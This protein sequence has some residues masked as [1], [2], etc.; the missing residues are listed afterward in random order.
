MFRGMSSG[1]SSTAAPS[2]ASSVQTAYVA[3][4]AATAALGGFLF[5]FD[6]AVINGA[7]SGL[8]HTYGSTSAGTGFAV[9]S[10][11]IGCAIGALLAGRIADLHGRRIVMIV[12]AVIFALTAAGAGLASST[13]L[14]ILARFISGI[15]VGAASV[16]CP[17]YIAEI[18]P[19]GIRGRLASLQQ[20]GIVVGIFAALL[21]DALI[22]QAAGGVNA[23]FHGEEAWRWM[24]IVE[25]A[26]S[27]LFGVAALLIPESPRFLLA[28]RR[29]SA[30]LSVLQRIDPGTAD[31]TLAEIEKTV[32]AE[33]KPSLADLRGPGGTVLAIVWIGVALSALQ[34]LVGINSIFYYG[35][36][37]WESVG[38]TQADSLRIN[39][40]TS[41]VNIVSTFVAMAFVDKVGRRPLLLWGSVAMAVTLGVLV[42]TLRGGSGALSHNAGIVALLAANLYV[43]AF[44]VSWGPCVWILLG[45]MFPNSIRGSAMAL[46]VF[47]QWIANWLITVS[48][49]G[50]VSALG[51]SG[52]YAMYMFFAVL[53]FFFVQRFIRETRGRALEEM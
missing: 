23:D 16:V 14:F 39:V 49:P 17:A 46:A 2:S 10:I 5:G 24:F 7:I 18:S 26:P 29:K 52:A 6:S 51:P 4:L 38:F 1:P 20:M 12:S 43:F 22:A 53:A 42:F 30:A 11:L 40:L 37:L 3:F 33:R 45:E 48:F 47:A 9:A 28:V 27:I 31:E 50:I 25:V 32:H 36:L 19:P 21:S 44:G 41:I 35:A 8:Q 15:G 34:Q 13:A